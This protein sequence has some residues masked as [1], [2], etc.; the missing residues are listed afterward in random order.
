MRAPVASVTPASSMTM[1]SH[2]S[3]PHINLL[4]SAMS[5]MAPT[6]HTSQHTRDEEEDDIHDA[7][8]KT[9]FEHR[10]GLVHPHAHPI[11]VGIAPRAKIDI[12]P[13][14]GAEGCTVG[15]GDVAERVDA[16]DQRADE[17]EIDEGDKECVV[18]RAVICEEGCDGPGACE[19]RDYEEDQDVVGRECVIGCVDIHK[20]CEHS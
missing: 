1:S 18:A 10:T 6:H 9:R 15:V 11:D 16:C 5:H 7:Q 8:R 13:R 17:T 20:E 14:A 12:V 4:I 3:L 19:D 2:M